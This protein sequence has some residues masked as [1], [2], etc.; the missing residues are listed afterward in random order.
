[1]FQQ[2]LAVFTAEQERYYHGRA[3]ETPARQHSSVCA[4]CGA[5]QL[6]HLANAL[7]VLQPKREGNLDSYEHAL[8]QG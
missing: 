5:A 7:L 6:L 1:M 8:C 3:Q 4:A 2:L